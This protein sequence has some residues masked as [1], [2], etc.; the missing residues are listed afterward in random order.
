VCC[1][2]VRVRISDARFVCVGVVC[3]TAE[4]S[5]M[6]LVECG[7]HVGVLGAWAYAFSV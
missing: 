1:T 5:G 7:V 3:A 6:S 2:A 4:T